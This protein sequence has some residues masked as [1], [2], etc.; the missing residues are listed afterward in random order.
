MQVFCISLALT[1]SG[2]F[3]T[4]IMRVAGPFLLE[5]PLCVVPCGAGSCF[6]RWSRA[7]CQHCPFSHFHLGLIGVV[8][9]RERRAGVRIERGEGISRV[10]RKAGKARVERR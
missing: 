4:F 8:P 2:C 1:V 5:V 3:H 9:S 10:L 6:P 7:L